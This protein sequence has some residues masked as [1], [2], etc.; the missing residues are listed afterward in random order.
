MISIHTSLRVLE[1]AVR[2]LG[3]DGQGQVGMRRLAAELVERLQN[4]KLSI[5]NGGEIRPP[6]DLPNVNV[7]FEEVPSILKPDRMRFGSVFH[8]FSRQGR[9]FRIGLTIIS[10]QV[11]EIDH[12]VLTQINTE[13]T[14]SLRNEGERE[15]AIRNESSDLFG[16]E[17][18]LQVMSCGQA[19]ASASY[20]DIP[21]PIHVP[22]FKVM[23]GV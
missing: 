21:I 1:E 20:R 12:G 8:D 19:I 4:G 9:K 5:F 7:V 22:R 6:D 3:G 15:E 18:E 14:M 10:Q 17:G 13:L 23:E 11:S 16:F 2:R